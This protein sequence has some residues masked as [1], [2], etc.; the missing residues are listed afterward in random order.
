MG[1]KKK[2]KVRITVEDHGNGFMVVGT[3][4]YSEAARI[5]SEYVDNIGDYQFACPTHYE[6]RSAC[7]L[8][9]TPGANWEGS[10]DLT[11]EPLPR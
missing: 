8:A 6:G 11:G 3:S 2:S 10:L 4:D 1:K 5:L 9:T 7:W